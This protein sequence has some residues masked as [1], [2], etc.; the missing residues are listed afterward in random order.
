MSCI[1][2][3]RGDARQGHL[4]EIF[5]QWFLGQDITHGR[6]VKK[7][8]LG[9]LFFLEILCGKLA[10]HPRIQLVHFFPIAKLCFFKEIC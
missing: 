6:G 2:W 3:G 1:G 7:C 9:G 8:F 4:H 10:P 5:H